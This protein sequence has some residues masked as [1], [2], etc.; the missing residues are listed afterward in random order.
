[1]CEHCAS[2]DGARRAQNC[3]LYTSVCFVVFVPLF[4]MY[5]SM[6][7]LRVRMYAVCRSHL[8]IVNVREYEV[9]GAFPL[10]DDAGC[11]WLLLA[12]ACCCLVMDRGT[13]AT[14]S[15]SC[16]NSGEV[17]C[18]SWWISVTSDAAAVVGT[19]LRSVLKLFLLRRSR[20][21]CWAPSLRA[22]F[23]QPYGQ[24]RNRPVDRRSLHLVPSPADWESEEGCQA[25]QGDCDGT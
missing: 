16:V 24:T 2:T 1:M 7:M 4:A 25:G 15:L 22:G 21:G 12:A 20:S 9:Q 19:S 3:A 13:A 10:H 5:S 8:C 11:C 14:A 6:F 17:S 18:L 23:V